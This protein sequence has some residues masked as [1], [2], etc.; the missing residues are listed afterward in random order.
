MLALSHDP[1]GAQAV[2]RVLVVVLLLLSRQ[3]R[4]MPLKP[5]GRCSL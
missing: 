1:G 2:A 5:L 4:L 3:V